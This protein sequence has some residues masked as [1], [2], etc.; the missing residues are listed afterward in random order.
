MS[1]LPAKDPTLVQVLSLYL[2]LLAFFV[3]LFNASRFDQ[4]KADAVTESLSSTFRT[5]GQPDQPIFVRSSDQGQRPGNEVILEN[6]SDLIRTELSVAKVENL[7]RGR[8][9]RATFKTEDLFESGTSGIRSDRMDLMRELARMLGK[10]TKGQRHKVEIVVGSPWITPDQ[11]RKSVPLPVARAASF[12]EMLLGQGALDGTV[13][14]GVGFTTP[15][16]VSLV[17]R[18]DPALR[19]PD[20]A[21]A[22]TAVQ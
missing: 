14:G 22:E 10:A 12:S 21:A 20:G 19:E 3:L 6:V 7:R 15:D 17:Y 13:S 1:R 8:L 18:L 9:L 4:G 11:I 16:T 5:Y 2:L